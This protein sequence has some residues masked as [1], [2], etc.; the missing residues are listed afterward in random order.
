MNKDLWIMI[1]LAALIVGVTIWG[2]RHPLF[3]GE[4][5]HHQFV[6]FG[7]KDLPLLLVDQETGRICFAGV[8]PAPGEYVKWFNEN[9]GTI[10]MTNPLFCSDVVWLG[11]KK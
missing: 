8:P 3:G 6:S 11:E 1:G 7:V 2:P 4:K 5:Q 10:T 9:V